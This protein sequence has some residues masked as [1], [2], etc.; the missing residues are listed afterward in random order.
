MTIGVVVEDALLERKVGCDQDLRR[1]GAFVVKRPASVGCDRLK[2][3]RLRIAAFAQFDGCD[4]AARG[5]NDTSAD[6][7]DPAPPGRSLLE[8]R[9]W[10]R[11]GRKLHRREDLHEANRLCNTLHRR[12]FSRRI[13]G[14]VVPARQ[15]SDGLASKDLAPLGEAAQPSGDVQR[16]AAIAARG[17]DRLSCVEA[18]PDPERQCWFALSPHARAPL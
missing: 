13:V 15:V 10:S 3:G 2:S 8:R 11:R 6:Q 17:R 18:D 1:T 14:L 9:S 12:R 5:K 16:A 4:S 7:Q